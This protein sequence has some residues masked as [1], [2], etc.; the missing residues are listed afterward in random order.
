MKL[1]PAIIFLFLVSMV[2]AQDKNLP[3]Y[4]IPAY[5]ESY[6]AGG[7]ASRIIDGL[8]FRFYWATEGL[9]SEDL[10]FKPGADART[11]EETIIHVYDVDYGSKCN[12]QNFK[13][14]GSSYKSSFC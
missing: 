13:L 10:A 9:R 6:T 2:T 12:N 4:E 8:G 11:S 3:Y 5:P 1:L 14:S 7:V